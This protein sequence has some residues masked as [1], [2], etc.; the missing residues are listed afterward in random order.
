[1]RRAPVIHRNW[2][3]TPRKFAASWAGN[4]SLILCSRFW[5]ALGNGISRIRTA[6]RKLPA[7]RALDKPKDKVQEHQPPA[8]RR[9]SDV[10][11]QR[12]GVG[13]SDGRLPSLDEYRIV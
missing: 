5:R 2:W 13:L 6:T 10:D 9:T 3:P 1:S 8:I 12:C 11:C 7:P 4:R